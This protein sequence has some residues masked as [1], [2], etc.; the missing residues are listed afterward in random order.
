MRKNKLKFLSESVLLEETGLPLANVISVITISLMLLLFIIWGNYMMMEE[1]VVMSG[2]VSIESDSFSVLGYVSSNDAVTIQNNAEAYITIPGIT[3]R[4]A[5]RGEVKD[6]NTSP[7]YDDSG[8]A[9]YGISVKLLMSNSQNQEMADRLLEGMESQ[10]SIVIDEK[11]LIQYLLG[12]L[13][14][15][16]KKAFN[17]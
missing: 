5:I 6:I 17:F 9:Y 7:V 1:D 14:D 16:G 8:K 11:T 10:V 13:Y 12:N 2:K 4:Q 3:S 15:T